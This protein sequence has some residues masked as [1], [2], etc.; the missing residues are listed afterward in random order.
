MDPVVG[1]QYLL[2]F[3]FFVGFF[4]MFGNIWKNAETAVKLMDL[5]ISFTD[6]LHK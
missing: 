6:C 3:L 5:M 2:F 1:V 4:K